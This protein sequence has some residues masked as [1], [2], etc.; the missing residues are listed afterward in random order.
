M[1]FQHEMSVDYWELVGAA[2]AGGIDSIL[3]EDASWDL[4][5]DQGHATLRGKTKVRLPFHKEFSL[6]VD[7]QEA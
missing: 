4:K 6:I 2:P 7:L 5:L 3:N 1:F